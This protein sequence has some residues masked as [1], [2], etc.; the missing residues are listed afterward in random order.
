MLVGIATLV[1]MIGSVI[2]T[3][4]KIQSS[5][6]LLRQE[7]KHLSGTVDRLTA[8]VDSSTSQINGHGERFASVEA[9]LNSLE[10][11]VNA[12]G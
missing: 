11:T 7:I 2:W 4:G 8:K 10:K 3:V 9:R 12:N 5:S 1:G 6:D